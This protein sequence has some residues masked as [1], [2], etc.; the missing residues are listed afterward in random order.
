MNF[1]YTILFL[2][3]LN[4]SKTY[5]QDIIFFRDSS[6]VIAIIKEV[7]PTQIKYNLYA[8]S[9][10][11]PVLS[12]KWDINKIVYKNG[13]I[14]VFKEVKPYYW[15]EEEDKTQEISNNKRLRKR[16]SINYNHK[17]I[18]LFNPVQLIDGAIGLNYFRV[19]SKL[20]MSVSGE[21]AIGRK[22][23]SP[24]ISDGIFMR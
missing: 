2:I 24:L 5:A 18:I 11:L 6:K 13:Y 21:F 19:I 10:G 20:H 7:N 3:L 8:D 17:N 23:K 9:A 12:F 14:E 16:D 4:V 22:N 15:K 1:K